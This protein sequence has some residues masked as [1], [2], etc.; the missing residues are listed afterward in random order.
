MAIAVLGGLVTSTL[1]SLLVVP[2]VFTWVDD[3]ER[4]LG[5]LVRRVR[6]ADAKP[7]AGAAGPAG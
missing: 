5:W 6:R 3:A 7:A 2:A 1:L 4:L